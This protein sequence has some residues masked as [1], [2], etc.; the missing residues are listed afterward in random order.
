MVAK[1]G[2][3]LTILHSTTQQTDFQQHMHQAG[4][5]QRLPLASHHITKRCYMAGCS[6]HQVL[7]CQSCSGEICKTSCLT[8]MWTWHLSW[9]TGKVGSLT[10]ADIAECH[11]H[12]QCCHRRHWHKTGRSS[13]RS[14]P[15]LRL[16]CCCHKEPRHCLCCSR[17]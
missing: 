4:M 2:L 1:C 17:R 15:H 8:H 3:G 13:W 7:P 6:P 16:V 14:A 11:K 5:Q 10:Q 12:W 9:L